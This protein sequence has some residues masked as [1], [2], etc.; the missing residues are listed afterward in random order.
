MKVEVEEGRVLQIN[1]E[2]SKEEQEKNDK[3]HCLERSGG[4]FLCRF[5]LP[6]TAKQSKHG[7]WGVDCNDGSESRGKK[8][9]VK[10]IEISS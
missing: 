9:E 6:E 10:A 4:K 7:E 3:W 8:P 1:G 5:R 2:R